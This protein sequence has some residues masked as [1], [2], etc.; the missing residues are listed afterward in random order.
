[1][2]QGACG[3]EESLTREAWVTRLTLRRSDRKA[4]C[5]RVCVCEGERE[6]GMLVTFWRT[7]SSFLASSPAPGRR[8]LGTRALTHLRQREAG[9]VCVEF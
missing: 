8:E 2:G 6:S 3:R 5:V 4:G 1:M 9:K 7:E